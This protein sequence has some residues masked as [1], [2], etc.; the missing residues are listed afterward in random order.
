M[1]IMYKLAIQLKEPS[2][3]HNMLPEVVPSYL[4]WTFEIFPFARTL[5]QI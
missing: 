2:K 5:I 4:V 3:V 1:Q